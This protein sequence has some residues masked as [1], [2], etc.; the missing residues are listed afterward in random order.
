MRGEETGAVGRGGK[1]WCIS[2]GHLKTVIFIHRTDLSPDIWE[3]INDRSILHFENII[4]VA[5]V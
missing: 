1:G 3:G 2:L 4:T 5:P